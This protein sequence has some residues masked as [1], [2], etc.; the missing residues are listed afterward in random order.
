MALDGIS[1]IV[2]SGERNHKIIWTGKGQYKELLTI[3]G[4]LSN[5][6]IANKIKISI[7]DKE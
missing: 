5:M 6:G 7:K 4:D 3:A 1:V 2:W